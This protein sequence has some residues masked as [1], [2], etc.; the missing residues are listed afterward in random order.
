M[1]FLQYLGF[2]GCNFDP[3]WA[4]KGPQDAYA[5]LVECST[6]RRR[7]AENDACLQAVE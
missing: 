3:I 1:R 5:L 6:A 4:L 2:P 7:T